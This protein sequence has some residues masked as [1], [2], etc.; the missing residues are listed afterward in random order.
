MKITINLFTSMA[1]LLATIN[2]TAQNRVSIDNESSTLNWTG[3]KVIGEHTGTIKL[4]NSFIILDEKGVKN[5]EINIEMTSITNTDMEGEWSDKLVG[6]L[7]SADFFDTVKHPNATFTINEVI[8]KSE[9]LHL[10]SGILTIKGISNPLS[11]PI[12]IKNTDS[13]MEITGLAEVDRTLYGVKYGSASFFD[14]LGDK[15]I[16]NL[17]ELN[18]D[19][20]VQRK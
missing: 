4:A 2:C 14:S 7:K 9:T 3:K 5:G 18:F 13:M 8:H 15:A 19:L 17:F 10:A 20:K 16:N 6:H 1:L 12:Q 11:F